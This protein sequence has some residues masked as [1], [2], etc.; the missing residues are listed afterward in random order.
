MMIRWRNSLS[1]TNGTEPLCETCDS[2]KTTNELNDE[3]Q[4]AK[5]L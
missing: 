1:D 2:K 5:P 4:E 3:L